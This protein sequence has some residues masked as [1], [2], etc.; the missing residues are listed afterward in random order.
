[1]K[2]KIIQNKDIRVWKYPS[3]HKY[4]SLLAFIAKTFGYHNPSSYSLQ[5]QDDEGDNINITND[6]DIDD[7]LLFATEECRKSLKIYVI[8]STA[9]DNFL[10]DALG[11]IFGPSPS[12]PK[13]VP[14]K[15]KIHN[16]PPQ[17]QPTH[18]SN[19]QPQIQAIKHINTQPKLPNPKPLIP[20]SNNNSH[21]RALSPKQ[22]LDIIPN[23]PARTKPM[24]PEDILASMFEED[25]A[26]QSSPIPPSKPSI[27]SPQNILHSMAFNIEPSSKPIIDSPVEYTPPPPPEQPKSNDTASEPES[28][29][30]LLHNLLNDSDMP[31]APMAM[32]DPQDV[33][34]SIVNK[35]DTPPVEA[36]SIKVIASDESEQE[37]RVEESVSELKLD[38][39]QPMQPHV[40]IPSIPSDAP[41]PSIASVHSTNDNGSEPLQPPEILQPK[42]EHPYYGAP[43]IQTSVPPAP[44][45]QP[46]PQHRDMP[47]G[48]DIPNG[49]EPM[50]EGNEEK[51]SDLLSVLQQF[52]ALP[53]VPAQDVN[54]E[55]DVSEEVVQEEEEGTHEPDA[56]TLEEIKRSLVNPMSFHDTNL[57]QIKADMKIPDTVDDDTEIEMDKNRVYVI[58]ETGDD[59][60]VEDTRDEMEIEPISNGD[61][62]M[63]DIQDENVSN[64]NGNDNANEENEDEIGNDNT[65]AVDNKYQNEIDQLY[66]ELDGINLNFEINRIQSLNA[67]EPDAKAQLVNAQPEDAQDIRIVSNEDDVEKDAMNDVEVHANEAAAIQISPM[68]ANLVHQNMDLSADNDNESSHEEEM[69]KDSEHSD[70]PALQEEIEKVIAHDNGEDDDMDLTR[71]TPDP[72]HTEVPS[73]D[74]DDAGEASIDIAND[75]EVIE[76][77]IKENIA[78]KIE[79]SSSNSSNL[80]S[81]IASNELIMS[82]RDQRREIARI[83][84]EEQREQQKKQK[85]EEKHERLA[86]RKQEAE[87]RKAEKEKQKQ[88]RLQLKEIQKTS[89]KYEK[90]RRTRIKELQQFRTISEQHSEIFS[91]HKNWYPIKFVLDT[92]QMEFEFETVQDLIQIIELQCVK[93]YRIC[94]S[95]IEC[96]SNADNIHCH[97]TLPSDAHYMVYVYY[98]WRGAL[99][100]RF[101]SVNLGLREAYISK[102]NVF[103]IPPWMNT[104]TISSNNDTND[105]DEPLQVM[106]PNDVYEK[107]LQS[108]LIKHKFEQGNKD[109]KSSPL[110]LFKFNKKSKEDTAM[111]VQTS[112]VAAMVLLPENCEQTPNFRWKFDLTQDYSAFDP[113]FS[114]AVLCRA[115]HAY[116]IYFVQIRNGAVVNELPRAYDI[117]VVYLNCCAEDEIGGLLCNMNGSGSK[118]KEEKKKKNELRLCLLS[119][120][121]EDEEDIVAEILSYLRYDRCYGFVTVSRNTC[122]DVHNPNTEQITFHCGSIADWIPCAIVGEKSFESDLLRLQKRAKWDNKQHISLSAFLNSIVT[123]YTM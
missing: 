29:D 110:A 93:Q 75:T 68:D 35:Q 20:M 62:A 61:E 103:R 36:V 94:P 8:S 27:I 3:H 41:I 9:M 84:R 80:S 26:F 5:Y 52:N 56:K 15:H 119:Y 76:E 66:A 115:M 21:A 23:K 1:M 17:R 116:E 38:D 95:F 69:V 114:D 122:V 118:D 79:Q 107:L 117:F 92:T 24:N 105:D 54:E 44:F 96:V 78:N 112:K 13:H 74:D 59:D 14:T 16:P 60:A 11:D 33:I 49:N 104:K 70:D 64:M 2:I 6:N 19:T 113:L 65:V 28:T 55:A 67:E 97:I 51:E 12:K 18:R 31:H 85:L 106:N 42:K 37:E 48:V 57:E 46:T 121:G 87:V 4:Q 58:P 123:T 63:D 7:A 10:D 81:P 90:L 34:N 98:N 102:V 45:L 39:V 25:L 73:D 109:K 40:R 47:N 30:D 43:T 89:K 120:L 82:P 50:E 22:M 72:V 99:N 101:Q 53:D 32:M 83:V 111:T 108:Q 77:A 86:L 88:K 100:V 91:P 71:T